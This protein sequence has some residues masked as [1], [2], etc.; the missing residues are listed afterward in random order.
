MPAASTSAVTCAASPRAF[1]GAC[2]AC[3]RRSEIGESTIRIGGGHFVGCAVR[4]RDDHRRSVVG[5]ALDGDSSAV[6]VE[7]A[8]A[9]RESYPRAAWLRREEQLEHARQEIGRD[10]R[11]VILQAGGARPPRPH[12]K[13]HRGGA[14]P[15]PRGGN[16]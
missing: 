3:A 7:D 11:S 6:I 13:S 9:E 5:C 4:Q 10:R 8:L 2:R 12:R 1:Q 15:P 16:A 14:S